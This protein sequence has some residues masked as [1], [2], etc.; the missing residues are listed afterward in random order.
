MHDERVEME[1]MQEIFKEFKGKKLLF[2]GEGPSIDGDTI[3]LPQDCLPQGVEVPP[4]KEIKL[5]TIF[6]NLSVQGNTKNNA[7]QLK[8]N[9]EAMEDLIKQYPEDVETYKKI[10]DPKQDGG[11]GTAEDFIS[12]LLRTKK[13]AV[14]IGCLSA[15]DRTGFI[16]ERLMLNQLSRKAQYVFERNIFNRDWPPVK[17]LLENTP[18]YAALKVVPSAEWRGFSRYD[19]LVQTANVLF[20]EMKKRGGI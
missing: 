2:N 1:D 11:Y 9:Q 4:D 14:S 16:A 18:G 15:K 5:R 13:M 3:S 19:K 6:V 12:F 10:G 8:I 17:V 20:H 7:A